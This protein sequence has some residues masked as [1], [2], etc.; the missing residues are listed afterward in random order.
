M[1]N[2]HLP[3]VEPKT[4]EELKRVNEHQAEYWSARDLQLLLG[5]THW[6][7]FENAIKKAITSC[8]QSGNN[9]EHH[10]ARAKWSPWA[11][12]LSERLMITTSPVL[13][14]T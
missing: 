1:S 9:A 5:Y 8:S 2:E 10:F 6:R 4:F 13:P 3:A 14:V 7:S 11:M 12:P